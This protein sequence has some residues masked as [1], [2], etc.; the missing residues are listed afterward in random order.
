[1]RL[2]NSVTNSLEVFRASK[3]IQMD[4]HNFIII[5]IIIIIIKAIGKD[6]K[7]TSD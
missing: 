5:I 1:M 3:L 7:M 2:T 4:T 6:G